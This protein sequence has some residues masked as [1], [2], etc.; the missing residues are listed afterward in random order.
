VNDTEEDVKIKLKIYLRY[1]KEHFEDLS[2][3]THSIPK[4]GQEVCFSLDDFKIEEHRFPKK[5]QY[6]FTARITDIES[7]AKL[8]YKGFTFFVETEPLA[9]GIFETFRPFSLEEG[10]YQ[11]AIGYVN[12]SDSDGL[13]LNYNVLHPGYLAVEDDKEATTEYLFRF[14]AME[15]VRID[16]G[17]PSPKIVHFDANQQD[18]LDYVLERYNLGMGKLFYYFYRGAT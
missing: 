15:L 18:D 17:S 10:E 3:T 12:T 16:F 13:V 7:A 2:E 9:K 5:G 8:D 11:Y 1:G 6:L 14:A 4:K